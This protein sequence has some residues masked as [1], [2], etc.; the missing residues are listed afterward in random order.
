MTNLKLLRRITSRAYLCQFDTAY[1]IMFKL[2][3]SDIDALRA[4]DSARND[5]RPGRAPPGHFDHLIASMDALNR[6]YLD[7]HKG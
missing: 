2:D 6:F 5:N 7:L 4:I 1:L 3:R